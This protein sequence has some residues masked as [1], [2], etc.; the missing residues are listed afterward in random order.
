[1]NISVIVPQLACLLDPDFNNQLVNLSTIEEL[2]NAGTTKLQKI[3]EH[4]ISSTS[5]DIE[6]ILREEN[7]AQEQQG[8][9]LILTK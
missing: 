9:S 6:F 5:L 8:R 1:M 4:D 2:P 3:I 7:A